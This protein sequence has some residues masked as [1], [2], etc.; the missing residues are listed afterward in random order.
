MKKLAQA[1]PNDRMALLSSLQDLTIRTFLFT[2][3]WDYESHLR[4]LAN[5]V[6]E[7]T[8][9]FEHFFVSGDSHTMLNDASAFSSENVALWTWLSRMVAN[10]PA[11]VS[12]QP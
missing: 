10:D 11:W 2:T 1:F 4:A 5:D 7:P 9:H 6:L 3:P 8:G 12:V